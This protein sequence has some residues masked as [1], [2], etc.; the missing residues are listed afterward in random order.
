ML[1]FSQPLFLKLAKLIHEFMSV[2]NRL[3]N[4]LS[5]YV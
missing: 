3:H 2:T 1:Y 5:L 4:A